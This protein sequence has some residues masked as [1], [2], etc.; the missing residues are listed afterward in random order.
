MRGAARDGWRWRAD[1]DPRAERVQLQLSKWLVRELGEDQADQVIAC[2]HKCVVMPLDTAVALHAADLHREYKPATTDAVVDAT[3]RQFGA[4]LRT[5]DAHLE[6]LP[7][8]AFFPQ[9]A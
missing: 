9:P 7:E 6:K 8:V 4:E 2:T 1:T 5:C 3:V